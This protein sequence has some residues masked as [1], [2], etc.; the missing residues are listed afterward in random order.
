MMLAMFAV[1]GLA[2]MLLWNALMPLIFGIPPLGYLQAAG[3]LVLARLLFGGVGG[4]GG[5]RHHAGHVERGK[6]REKWL[7]MSEDERMKFI[8]LHKGFSRFHERF[9]DEKEMGK[10]NE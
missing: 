3:L 6:L 7:N 5:W 4:M 10:N 8:K 9:E 2:V 1:F